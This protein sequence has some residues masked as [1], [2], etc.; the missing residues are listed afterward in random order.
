M[1][2]AKLYREVSDEDTIMAASAHQTL[3][4]FQA[5]PIIGPFG[6]SNDP[7]DLIYDGYTE[8][9]P[10]AAHGL[11]V[12]AQQLAFSTFVLGPGDVSSSPRAGTPRVYSSNAVGARSCEV[13][14]RLP[15]RC[16]PACQPPECSL[17]RIGSSATRASQEA[18]RAHMSV[19]CTLL[20][21]FLR[22]FASQKLLCPG[23]FEYIRL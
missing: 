1:S 6:G 21:V 9:L 4:Q 11:D 5:R 7:T 14:P 8:E 18:Q 17:I 13:V 10:A 20:T 2:A 22:D 16:P 23:P 15:T 3:A 19:V 12:C